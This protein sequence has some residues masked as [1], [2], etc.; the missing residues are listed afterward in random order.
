MRF[1]FTISWKKAFTLIEMLIVIV[2]IGI[3]AAALIP[4]VQG[5]QERAKYTRVEK[6]FQLFQTSV[7]MAQ[8]N[9]NKDL[10]A[11]TESDCS[12]CFNSCRDWLDSKHPDC[13]QGWLDA[14]RK[15]EEASWMQSGGLHSLEKD[16]RW[17]PYLL[18]ENEGEWGCNNFDNIW[19]AGK[20]G[21]MHSDI[22]DEFSSGSVKIEDDYGVSIRSITCPGSY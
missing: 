20:D 21:L 7:F 10:R 5:I 11:I 19:T 8:T 2:I 3:L 1:L 9:T 15:I 13:T 4:K 14:L 6:D 18:N 22:D 12:M 17:N 16:P